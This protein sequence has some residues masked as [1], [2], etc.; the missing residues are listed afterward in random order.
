[1]KRLL[2]S[3]LVVAPLLA[4]ALVLVRRFVTPLPVRAA[5]IVRGPALA[6][7]FATGWIEAR[8]RRLLRPPRAAIVGRIFRKEGE[9]VRAG[10]PLVEL[11]DT[12]REQR[13][14][15]VRAELDGIAT[16]LAE[17]SALRSGAQARIRE[18]TV[19]EE[20]AAGETERARPLYEQKLIEQR[21]FLQLVANQEMAAAHRRQAEQDLAQT[22]EQ[23]QTQQRQL[24]AELETL[25][26]NTKDDKIVA[27]FDGVVLLRFAEEGESVNPE[28]DLMKF[29][30]LRDLLVEGEVDEEDV[31]R[32]K[33]GQR[34]LIRLAGDLSGPVEGEVTELFPDANRSTRSFRVRVRFADAAFVADGPLGL[35]GRLESGAREIVAGSSV[36]LGIVVD[37]KADARV[38]PRAALTARGTLFVVTD[39]RVRERRVELGIRNYD[40]CEV[41]G[42]AEAGELVAIEK[43][44][45]LDDGRRVEA[46]VEPESATSRAPRTLAVATPKSPAA[47]GAAPAA[48]PA[49]IVADELGRGRIDLLAAKAPAT[50]LIFT[51][52]DCP[53]SN[54]FAPEIERLCGRFAARGVACFLVFVD[55]KQSDADVR[56]HLKAYGL[57]ARVLLDRR[58]EI[59]KRFGATITPEAALLAKDGGLAYL[60]RIDD[61]F[62]DVSVQRSEPTSHDL[63]AAV[64]ALLAGRAPA[65]ARTTA[66][67]CVIEDLR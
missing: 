18:A 42:G 12:A 24:S 5:P 57:S 9:E 50:V 53:I 36:E 64:S 16:D 48:L 33:T 7:V 61:R 49:S 17:G 52:A 2:F 23:R 66:V 67:G 35:R 3:L 45:E 39:G 14:E 6:T 29:G 38:V 28:R 43:L 51:R 60:G 20:W 44:A 1:M 56:A 59:V 54:K 63:D 55:P 21:A 58:H 30:D 34:V 65:P 26:A 4:G 62:A 19:A 46:I 31:A 37:E 11:R 32:V 10:E 13:E 27:P 22:L 8:E 25:H 15:R 41:V 40:R 47:V